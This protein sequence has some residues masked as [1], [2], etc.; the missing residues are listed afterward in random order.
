MR[1]VLCFCDRFQGALF[2]LRIVSGSSAV[3]PADRLF[4]N[5]RIKSAE[6]IKVGGDEQIEVGSVDPDTLILCI[7]DVKPIKFSMQDT[8]VM[9]QGEGLPG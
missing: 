5:Q 1:R 7:V 2:I 9:A 4:G 8:P 6:Q 3:S